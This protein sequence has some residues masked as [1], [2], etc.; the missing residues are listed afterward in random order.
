MTGLSEWGPRTE[1][2]S[3]ATDAEI[4]LVTVHHQGCKLSHIDQCGFEYGDWDGPHKMQWIRRLR[5]G[6]VI[7]LFAT[8]ERYE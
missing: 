3:P 6:R 1:G 7:P 5:G 2:E 4:D 8:K